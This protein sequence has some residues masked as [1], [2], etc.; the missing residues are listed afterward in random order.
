MILAS[1]H[2]RDAAHNDGGSVLVVG[3]AHYTPSLHL[4]GCRIIEMQAKPFSARRIDAGDYFLTGGYRFDY[5]FRGVSAVLW[6]I[7]CRW[8][9]RSNRR[10]DEIGPLTGNNYPFSSC[11]ELDRCGKTVTP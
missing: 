6:V 5:S 8:Q 2:V 7:L 4:D 1:A 9:R 10:T 3:C 11:K